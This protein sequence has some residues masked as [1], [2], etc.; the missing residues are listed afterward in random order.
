MFLFIFRPPKAPPFDIVSAYPNKVHIDEGQTLE[1]AGLT[2]NAVL[3]LKLKK[4]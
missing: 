2:P 3:H 4:T 1:S